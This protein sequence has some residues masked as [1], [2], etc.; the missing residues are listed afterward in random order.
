MYLAPVRRGTRKVVMTD[1]NAVRCTSLSMVGC[2]Y[3]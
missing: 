3:T 1:G 2:S